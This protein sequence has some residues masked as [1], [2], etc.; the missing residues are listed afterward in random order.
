MIEPVG[1]SR[2]IHFMLARFSTC[3]PS[4]LGAGRKVKRSTSSC[5]SRRPAPEASSS[6]LIGG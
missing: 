4:T 2:R 1:A 6:A 3:R 5:P